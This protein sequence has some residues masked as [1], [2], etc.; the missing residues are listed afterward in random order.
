MTAHISLIFQILSDQQGILLI[1]SATGHG[2]QVL[3]YPLS[4]SICI[5]DIIYDFCYVLPPI[6]ILVCICFMLQFS[7]LLYQAILCLNISTIYY[8]FKQS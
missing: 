2:K 3:I 6:I 4:L 5:L 1:P 8:L 7:V